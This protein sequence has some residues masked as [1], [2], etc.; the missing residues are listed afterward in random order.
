[1]RGG[2][3]AKH[4]VAGERGSEE[5]IRRHAGGAELDEQRIQ[6]TRS[7]LNPAVAY[8]LGSNSRPECSC[9]NRSQPLGS[10]GD[11][12]SNSVKGIH[13]N[14][15]STPRLQVGIDGVEIADQ[16]VETNHCFRLGPAVSSMRL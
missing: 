6:N 9:P 5:W 10:A 11:I 16:S 12:R 3:G 14:F 15:L 4:I 1:M 2:Y 13:G 8:L 7:N